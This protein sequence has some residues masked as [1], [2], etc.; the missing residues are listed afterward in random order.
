MAD[1]EAGSG[2]AE[3]EKGK[4]MAL[5]E[6]VVAAEEDVEAKEATTTTAMVEE[7]V[8][9]I[10][11]AEVVEATTMDTRTTSIRGTN[12]THSLIS[13]HHQCPQQYRYRTLFQ[14]AVHSQHTKATIWTAIQIKWVTTPIVASGATKGNHIGLDQP[15]LIQ[16]ASS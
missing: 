8:S 6:E 11:E 2:A 9:T 13:N 14:V 16:R 15:H 3:T 12:N 7:V 5:E 1:A 10:T 4:T